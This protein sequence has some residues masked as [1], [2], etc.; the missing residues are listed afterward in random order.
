[1]S[2]MMSEMEWLDKFGD[3]L[4]EQLDYFGM[5]QRELAAE[6]N[7][8][9]STISAFIKKQKIPTVRSILNICWVLGIETDELINFGKPIE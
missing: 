1:M 9:E 2:T 6:A 4:K 3:T 8:A 5:S 7:L